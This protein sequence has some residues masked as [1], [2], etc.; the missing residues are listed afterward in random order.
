MKRS[1]TQTA[2]EGMLRL[3]GINEESRPDIRRLSVAEG[4]EGFPDSAVGILS[5]GN[6]QRSCRA[7]FPG[8]PPKSGRPSLT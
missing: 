2:G 6:V 1:E 7:A 4:Q 3:T 5:R 8:V